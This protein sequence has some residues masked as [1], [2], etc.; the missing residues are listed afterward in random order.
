MTRLPKQHLLLIIIAIAI[1]LSFKAWQTLLNNFMI[2]ELNFT[3]VTMGILQS[4]REV[5]GLLAFTLVFVLLLIKEQIAGLLSLLLMGFG[6]A[7]TGLSSS[8]Y[9]AYFFTIIMSIGFHYNESILKSLT[10][11]FSTQRSINQLMAKIR[12]WR[13]AGAIF[14]FSFVAFASHIL[15]LSYTLLFIICGGMTMLLA[16]YGLSFP[17]F[18]VKNTQTQGIVFKKRYMIYYALSFLKG[19]R[20]TVFV[21]FAAFLNGLGCIGI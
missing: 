3:G 7:L 6:V 12:F 16:F 11:Q 4:I 17:I 14:I 5:P 1:P 10:L 21:V 20:R 13:A 8:I 15:E 2:D 18:K 19:S 9:W